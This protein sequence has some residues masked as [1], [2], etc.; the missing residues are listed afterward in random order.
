VQFPDPVLTI[1]LFFP[2]RDALF[3]LLAGLSDE[4]WEWPTACADWSVLD[5]ARHM[6]GVDLAN[7]SNRRDR[8]SGLRPAAGEAIVPFV[9]RINDEWMHAARRLSPRVVREQLAAGGPPLF[10]YFASLEPLELGN[11]VSWAGL[12]PAPV[13]LDVAR[14]YTERW[15]HQQH[16][17]DAV[18]QPGQTSPEFLYPILATF[19]HAIPMTFRDLDAPSGTTVQLHVNGEAGGDWTIQREARRWQL[20]LGA[21]KLPTARVTLDP[22]TTW[23]LFTRG[24]SPEEARGRAAFEGDLV[25]CERLL[26]TVAIIA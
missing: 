12:D 15:H 24:M 18:G 26:R 25:L 8:Y 6:L 21:P 3:A 1:D 13:W 10:A 2:D 17:R 23:K 19:A 14:E 11:R 4:E 7:L 22:E 5:V 20:Y 16:I 9:N